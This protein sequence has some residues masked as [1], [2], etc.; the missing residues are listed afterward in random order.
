MKVWALCLKKRR[1]VK[2]RTFFLLQESFKVY[3][4]ALD[5]A[6]EHPKAIIV[7]IKD[8]QIRIITMTIT[9]SWPAVLC[10]LLLVCCALW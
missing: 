2:M 9:G 6:M 4:M 3:V 5:W 7:A 10:A 1:C 8:K